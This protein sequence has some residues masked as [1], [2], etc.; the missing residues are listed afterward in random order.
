MDSAGDDFVRPVHTH[1]IEQTCCLLHWR[2]AGFCIL[3]SL[4]VNK[5]AR[6]SA[7]GE[8]TVNINIYIYIYK[9]K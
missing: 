6:Y 4:T 5:C 1:Y 9:V 3:S 2:S 8:R 7:A